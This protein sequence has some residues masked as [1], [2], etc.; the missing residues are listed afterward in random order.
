[1][2]SVLF[3]VRRKRI[4]FPSLL[5]WHGFLLLARGCIIF[6]V[7]LVRIFSLISADV[8][9]IFIFELLEIPTSISRRSMK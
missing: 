4:V 5:L 8:G 6:A 7:G 9:E 1:L 3:V 2:C